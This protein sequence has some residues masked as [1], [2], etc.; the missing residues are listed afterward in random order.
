M[1]ETLSV[2]RLLVPTDFSDHATAAVRYASLLAARFDAEVALLHATML[3]ASSVPDDR[4]VISALEQTCSEH[5]HGVKTTSQV[6]DGKP[7]D[8]ILAI[9]RNAANLIVMGT[10]GRGGLARALLGSVAEDVIRRSDIPVLTMRNAAPSSVTRVLCPIN[11]SDAA[12]KA[13]RHALLFASA[14]DAELVALYF[15]ESASSDEEIE[16]EVE[17]LR[18]WLGDVPLSVRLTILAR[19]GEPATQL[20]EFVRTHE[21]DLVVV[22]AQPR[23][24]AGPETTIGTTTDALTRHAPCP[25]LTVSTGTILIAEPPREHASFLGQGA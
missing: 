6:V 1:S 8:A 15:H 13:F 19:R 2:R 11:Y 14:F 25:V 17:R 9:A 4:L 3:R 21:V 16:R 24:G 22:G 10:H 12:A 7:A 5:F 18:L 23:R 20:I